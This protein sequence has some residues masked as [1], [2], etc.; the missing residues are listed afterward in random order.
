MIFAAMF[1]HVD[2]WKENFYSRMAIA[3]KS[4]EPGNQ[5]I[6]TGSDENAEMSHMGSSSIPNDHTLVSSISVVR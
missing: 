2:T 1:A 6:T 4:Q 3:T 5:G